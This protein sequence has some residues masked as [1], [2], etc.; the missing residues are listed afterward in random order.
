MA[1]VK[2]EMIEKHS[3]YGVER[4][5]GDSFMV[6]PTIA[7]RLEYKKVAKT[8]PTG[9]KSVKF[10]GKLSLNQTEHDQGDEAND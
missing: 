5:V 3:V 10:G 7:D 8:V 4:E 1:D 9:K 6:H 2:V